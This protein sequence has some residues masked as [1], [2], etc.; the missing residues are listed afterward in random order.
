MVSFSNRFTKLS[1]FFL[2]A[3]FLTFTGCV[4]CTDAG[5]REYKNILR[6]VQQER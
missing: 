6:H 1:S 2:L 4:H 3:V 5:W